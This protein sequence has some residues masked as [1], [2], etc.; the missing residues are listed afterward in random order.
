MYASRGSVSHTETFHTE[1]IGF[2]LRTDEIYVRSQ[3]SV[4]ICGYCYDSIGWFV[5]CFA[6]IILYNILTNR[7][8]GLPYHGNIM[9]STVIIGFIMMVLEYLVQFIHIIQSI[10]LDIYRLSYWS[11]YNMI[12]LVINFVLFYLVHLAVYKKWSKIGFMLI[13][14]HI[15]FYLLLIYHY[16]LPTFLLMLVYPTKVIA[17]VAYLIAFVYVSIIAWSISV[18]IF[19]NAMKTLKNKR[20]CIRVCACIYLLYIPIYALFICFFLIVLFLVVYAILLNQSLS[21]TTGPVYTVL[22]LI[23][24]AAISF[25]SWMLKTKA[26]QFEELKNAKD[27][28][29]QGAANNNTDSEEEHIRLLTVDKNSS[30]SEPMSESNPNLRNRHNYGTTGAEDKSSETNC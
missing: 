14:S 16:A 15:L 23:P 8:T 29:E 30:A 5:L 20:T 2:V 11:W 7:K 17:I 4:I 28:N 3:V 18:Q 13:A 6:H 26:F 12:A 19:K 9:S 10:V 21:I 22:S 1:D 27:T 24:T 25:V